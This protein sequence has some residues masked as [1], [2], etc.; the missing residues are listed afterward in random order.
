MGVIT[1]AWDI[2]CGHNLRGVLYRLHQVADKMAATG[3][4]AVMLNHQARTARESHW[5][6]DTRPPS[7]RSCKCPPC[8]THSP[9]E[10]SSGH[11]CVLSKER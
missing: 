11:G 6:P 3:L 9:R 2:L 10:K 1:V 8:G 7:G 4:G 5:P